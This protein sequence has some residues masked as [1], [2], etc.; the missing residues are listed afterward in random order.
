MTS[1]F[2]DSHM[3]LGRTGNACVRVCV[4]ACVRACAAEC[5]GT[6]LRVRCTCARARDCQTRAAR[7][8]RLA[9]K[10]AVLYVGCRVLIA[11][12]SWNES[13]AGHD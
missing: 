6:T 9:I 3:T 12:L 8:G 2:L 7:A 1:R 11:A 13:E 10:Y 4:R 5:A